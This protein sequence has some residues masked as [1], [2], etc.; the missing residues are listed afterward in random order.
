MSYLFMF[1]ARL[2]NDVLFS[3]GNIQTYKGE[4]IKASLIRTIDIFIFFLVVSKIPK[5][6]LFI[7]G[8]VAIASG[9]GKYFSFGVDEIMTKD[10]T[11]LTLVKYKGEKGA[12]QFAID[13]LRRKNITVFSVNAHYN[14][15]GGETLMLF[16][17]NKNKETSRLV[18]KL[19]PKSANIISSEAKEY[20]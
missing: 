15:E 6:D 4:K 10:D 12:L 2:V 7:V 5:D 17:L 3:L 20:R 18:K 8:I 16:I 14:N 9:F 1:F 19:M 13:E 11:F